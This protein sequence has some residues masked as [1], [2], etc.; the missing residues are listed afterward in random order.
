MDGHYGAQAFVA[1]VDFGDFVIWRHDDVP[2]YQLAVV[3]DD[4]AMQITEVVRGADLLISTARQIL[5]YR[6]LGLPTPA[7][8]HCPLMMDAAGVR[9]AKRDEAVS[10]R[11]FREQGVPPESLRAAW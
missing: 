8:Y 10:L 1:G 11:S 2:A 4:D 7:F 3:V 9:L 5:L 6:A